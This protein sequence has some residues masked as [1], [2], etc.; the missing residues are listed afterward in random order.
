MMEEML[1]FHQSLFDFFRGR[2]C[3]FQIVRKLLAGNLVFG[4]SH[5][6]IDR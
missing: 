5:R 2:E 3:V 6:A 4:D 1:I